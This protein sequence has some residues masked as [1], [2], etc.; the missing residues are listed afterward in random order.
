MEVQVLND[1]A[2]TNYRLVRQFET[3]PF[4]A[5][6]V[7][8]DALAALT[9]SA[10]V[11][12]VTEDHL[13]APSLAESTPLVEAD[14]SW[15]A[16]FDGNGWTVVVLDDGAD[17]SHPFLSGKIVEEACFSRNGDCPNGTTTQMGAGAGVPCTYDCPHG[18][19]V[20]GIAVGQSSAFSGVARGASLIPI[21][22]FSRFTGSD[23]GP[24]GGTC[25]L[26]Y[27]TDQVAALEHVFLMLR[28]SHQ[29]AAVNMSLG[30][31]GFFD[32]ASCDAQKPETK[33]MIDNLRSVGIAT[34]VASG[35]AAFGDRLSA[36]ACISSAISVGNTTKADQVATSSNSAYF[37]SLLAPGTSISSSV[38]GGGFDSLTGTSMAAPHVAGAWAILKQRAPAATVD[39]V[40]HALQTT[41]LP[42][43]DPFNSVST[44]RIQVFQA[45]N[46]VLDSSQP[47]PISVTP[48][49]GSGS[50]QTFR[51]LYSDGSGASD[52]ASTSV[53]I[54]DRIRGDSACY[55][56]ISGSR[57]WLRNDANS[58]WLGPVTVG[59]ANSLSNS[60]CTLDSEDSSVSSSGNNLSVN[61]ALSFTSA[62]Y[63]DR[64]V[65]MIARDAGGQ[66]SGW[67]SQGSW[68]VTSPAVPPVP[69][70]VTPESGNGSEQTFTFLFSDL[71][72]AADI[73]VTTTLISSALSGN[74][75]CYVWS[76]GDRFWLRDDAHSA[77]LG[78]VTMGTT[79]SLTNSQ[80]SLDAEGSS[81]SDSG[82]NRTVNL[83]LSFTT[84]FAGDKTVYMSARDSGGWSLWFTRGTWTVPAALSFT[85][86]QT[87]RLIGTW[88]FTFTII[89]QFMDTFRLYDVQPSP[90]TP[91]VWNIFGVDQFN[92]SVIAGYSPILGEFS[93]LNSGITIDEFFTFDFTG[94][95]TVSG[96]YY[97]SSPGS[98]SLGTCF[99]MTGVRISTSAITS[100]ADI[101]KTATV[102]ESQKLM[103]SGQRQLRIDEDQEV[104]QNI[105][106]ELEANRRD[107]L[108]HAGGQ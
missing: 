104:G 40:L 91:G 10:G 30:G 75:A 18:T 45:L 74:N 78:P 66:S 84:A 4:L 53:V 19:H 99:P 59:A 42:I 46:A 32:Q 56:Q 94:T 60:Q 25:A 62:F 52:I 87:E 80:C 29:I 63:G 106:R 37:L 89:S 21:Q 88:Q 20:A 61:L 14:R 24:S 67:Q 79:D 6:E 38:P 34:V 83:A 69:I 2:G 105:V 71:N 35:N 72:G 31:G 77:W 16:G 11:V 12:G 101:S 49:S 81:I 47:A 97:Q 68:R 41:G 26:S 39:E 43:V 36:P 96:C 86:L 85:Q 1:L 76:S 44:P 22:V 58:G 108:R 7:E 5:L 15:T 102:S 3:I 50:E 98:N 17:S 54:A 82:N 107:L 93:L 90:D 55:L 8:P 70:S 48:S 95:H 33:A 100:T 28:T 103:E 27:T 65:F 57:M 73:E 13:Y 23:C 92:G 64:T 51:F 9:Q